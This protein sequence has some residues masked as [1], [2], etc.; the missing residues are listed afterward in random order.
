MEK[1]SFDQAKISIVLPTFNESENVD[2]M[3]A[4]LVNIFT[5]LNIAY[6]II[7]VDDQSPDGTIEKIKALREKDNH[8]KYLLM[9]RRFGDQISIMAGIHH[10]TGDMVVTMDSDLQH[11]PGYIR[12]MVQK[13]QEGFD[14]I[15][16]RREE[17]GH[18][19]FFKK[20]SEIL[21][22]KI[23]GNLSNTPIYYRF[24]GYVLLD[25]R[26]VEALKSF[27]ESDPFF[28]GLVGLIGF[29]KTELPYQEAERERG[30][31][32]YHLF[33]MF[34]LA[35]T[36]ITSFS[37]KPLYLSFYL[38]M[39]AVS[40]S[41]CY[42]VYVFISALFLDVPVAGWASMILVVIFIGGVQLISTGVL[43]I[44]LSKVF[45]DSKNRPNYFV[46]E[47]GG[48]ADKRTE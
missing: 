34:R 7:F 18:A 9:S 2:E 36:G 43:G 46:A 3:Y 39:V 26:A 30:E 41:L 45:I 24:S 25:R 33:D 29:N 5:D 31:S 10:A 42:A 35:I 12:R 13:W 17:A 8:V 37:D 27:K 28:R 20:W 22:Y 1:R 14:I 19:S 38:G 11:P 32:K 40:I 21:F 44:F 48:I 6:E 4:Q 47:F 15:I 16:M 23:L